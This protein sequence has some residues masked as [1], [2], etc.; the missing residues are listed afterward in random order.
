M[1]AARNVAAL[2]NIKSNFSVIVCGNHQE[3]SK[4][5]HI[6]T[7]QHFV[8]HAMQR[9]IVVVRGVVMP[10]GLQRR[11]SPFGG[12]VSWWVVLRAS[13]YANLIVGSMHLSERQR[14]SDYRFFVSSL[15]SVSSI[16]TEIVF[17]LFLQWTRLTERRRGHAL[18]IRVK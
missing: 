18:R 13:I 15:H 17:L 5:S 8:K 16:V 14:S 10:N 1:E 12:T 6:W 9:F 2:Y 11:R 4:N 7:E 3:C